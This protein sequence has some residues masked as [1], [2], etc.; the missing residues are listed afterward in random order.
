MPVSASKSNRK[1]IFLA[2]SIV[3]LSSMAGPQLS[4][5]QNTPPA[6]RQKPYQLNPAENHKLE[7]LKDK[8]D[9][10]DLPAYTGKSKF[11]S[12][13][14]EQGSKGGPRY[15]MV[16]ET[17]E[18]QN[19]VIDW[20][21]NVFRMYK[22]TDIQKSHSSISATHKDGHFASIATDALINPG[23]PS[24]SRSSFTI[25]YQMSVR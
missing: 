22:W 25:Q 2:A 1:W 11:I 4:N 8:V 20:Y 21:E 18:P 16:F 3:V 7:N 5:A 23:V 14:V 10:P 6:Y 12:G 9:L 15:Q 19:Q 17:E 24:R 13:S